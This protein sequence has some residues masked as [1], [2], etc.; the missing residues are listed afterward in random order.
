MTYLEYK[1]AVTLLTERTNTL[2]NAVKVKNKFWHC[3]IGNGPRTHSGI[4]AMNLNT[5]GQILPDKKVTPNT[6]QNIKR[7]LDLPDNMLMDLVNLM[8]VQ[9]QFSRNGNS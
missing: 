8:F 3:L 7:L 2:N 4:L 9:N 1:N 6:A 5:K